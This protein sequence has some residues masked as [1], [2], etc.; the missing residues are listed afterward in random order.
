MSNETKVA[1]LAIVAIG[2]FYWGYRFVRGKN[3][4]S[5]SNIYFVEYNHINQL[6]KS[7]PV[8]INGFEVGFVADMYL[9]PDNH[10]VIV[11]KLDLRKDIKVPDNTLAIIK[12]TGFMG[13]KA[14]ILEYDTPCDLKGNCAES[15]SYLKGTTMGL[16]DS[17]VGEENLKSYMNVLKEGLKDVIDTLNRELLSED[18]EGPVAESRRSLR[19]TRANLETSTGRLDGILAQSSGNI[20]GT[21][22][23]LR[24]ITDNIAASNEKIDQIIGNANRLTNDLAEADLKKTVQEIG[25]ALD[26]LNAT[27]HSADSAVAGVAM[28]IEKI[29]N[30]EGTIGKLLNDEELYVRLNNLSIQTDSLVEDFQDRP[31]RYMPFKSRKKVKKYDKKDAKETET[32]LGQSSTTGG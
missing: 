22:A 26:Q 11:V 19:S 28:A 5:S 8:L 16:L 3:I 2:L 15:G 9:K 18:A 27:L 6:K 20:N 23:N 1:I 4:L 29:N 10:E 30:G 25:N 12:D 7:S 14:I 17:M 13:G 31:Y 21:L 32:Q 24:S